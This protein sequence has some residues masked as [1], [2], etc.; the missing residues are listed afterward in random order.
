MPPA[1]SICIIRDVPERGRPETMVISIRS[2]PFSDEQSLAQRSHLEQRVSCNLA[3]VRRLAHEAADAG[4]LS[5]KL[6]AGIRSGTGPML[7][8]AETC[9]WR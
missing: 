8:S 4:L 7:G 1:A 9:Q 2:I 3:A 6:A 5:R